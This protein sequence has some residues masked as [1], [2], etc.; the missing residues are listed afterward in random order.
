M[1]SDG[2]NTMESLLKAAEEKFA[3]NGFKGTTI[4]SICE[5][6]G[7]N[8]ALVSHYFGSKKELYP[9]VCRR[10]FDGQAHAVEHLADNVDG[11]EAWQ[12]AM[13]RWIDALLD[14]AT[15]RDVRKRRIA[16]IFR[17]E[18]TDPSAVNAYLLKEFGTPILSCLRRLVEMALPE[19]G[20]E[21]ILLWMGHI[22][23][24]ISVYA[25]S[26]DSWLQKFRPEEMP[27]DEW[28][29]HVGGHLAD[30]VFLQLKYRQGK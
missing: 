20:E 4:R 14:I 6:A 22:W 28:A 3:E 9:M 15:S 13:R 21:Q 1:R 10:L 5:K 30:S 7:A 29:K 25:L 18:V 16:R 27:A 17:H 8:I 26:D 12:D 19:G 11:E 2:E 23:L 24:R